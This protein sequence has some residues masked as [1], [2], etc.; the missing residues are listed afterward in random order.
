MTEYTPRDEEV[1]GH[2]AS[3]TLSYLLPDAKSLLQWLAAHDA[4]VERATAERA[5]DDCAFQWA[6][7]KSGPTPV[8]PYRESGE[9]A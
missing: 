8:N 5:W 3:G 9:S 1:I 2:A 7:Y 6:M 4:E